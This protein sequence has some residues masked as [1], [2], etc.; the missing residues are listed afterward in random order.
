M[1]FFKGGGEGWRDWVLNEG[2]KERRKVLDVKC[3]PTVGDAYLSSTCYGIGTDS[4]S[5]FHQIFHGK[6]GT[7]YAWQIGCD[8][9]LYVVTL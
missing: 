6:Y 4:L 1:G 8:A 5:N 7:Y 9:T 2:K 3:I